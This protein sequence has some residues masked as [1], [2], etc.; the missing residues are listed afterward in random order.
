MFAEP[1]QGASV[2]CTFLN[3]CPRSLGYD[4]AVLNE[5]REGILF[6]SASSKLS[7]KNPG[8]CGAANPRLPRVMAWLILD[9]CIG[10]LAEVEEELKD[11][12]YMVDKMELLQTSSLS[13]FFPK[14][15]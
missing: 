12:W 5:L 14:A 11:E 1:P 7:A 9:R 8:S 6:E 10:P 13:K 4:S 2:G 15:R 3:V